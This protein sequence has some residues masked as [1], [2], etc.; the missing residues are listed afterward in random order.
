MRDEKE[1]FRKFANKN[2]AAVAYGLKM[3]SD[4]SLRNEDL[5]RTIRSHPD[6]IISRV[7][8]SFRDSEVTRGQSTFNKPI[9]DPLNKKAPEENT[10]NFKSKMSEGNW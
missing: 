5:S 3:N 10:L 9:F 8:D 2:V 4:L 1:N 7:Q 6:P